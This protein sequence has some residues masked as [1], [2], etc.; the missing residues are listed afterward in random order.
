MCIELSELMLGKQSLG[1]LRRR[2]ENNSMMD[3]R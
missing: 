3:L 2:W 1:R